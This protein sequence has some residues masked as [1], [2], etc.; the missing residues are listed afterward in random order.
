MADRRCLDCGCFLAEAE[1]WIVT[2]DYPGTDPL[3]AT[4][5]KILICDRCLLRRS[6]RGTAKPTK[7]NDT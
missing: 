7:S 1:G 4:L 5:D 3:L 2:L 6:G